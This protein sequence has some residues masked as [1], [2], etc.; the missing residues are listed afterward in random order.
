M[1]S[2]PAS[3]GHHDHGV[4][5]AF[6]PLLQ[7][8][9]ESLEAERDLG[10][11][12]EVHLAVDQDGKGR[13]EPR[14]AAHELHQSDPVA[15]GFRFRVGRASRSPRLGDGGLESKGLLHERD[16][17]VDGLGN[18][19]HADLE[20]P[21]PRLVADRLRTAQRP[22]AADDEQ[23]ADLQVFQRLHHLRRVLWP[24]G[25]PQDRSA[26]LVDPHDRLR[27]QLERRVPVPADETFVAEAE[28]VDRPDAIVVMQAEHDRAYD[29]VQ[30]R[31]DPAAGHDPARKPRR[32]EEQHFPRARRLHRGRIFPPVVPGLQVLEARVIEDALA[33]AREANIRH[34][35]ANQALTESRYREVELAV[36]HVRLLT[37]RSGHAERS[38]R[39]GH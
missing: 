23:D 9:Q 37:I 34:R 33:V 26:D 36:T 4:A 18:A 17:V 6:D 5:P 2:W 30:P 1:R 22:V 8:R 31:A 21:P 15:R 27:R 32:V 35:R 13:D 7:Q 3:F 28:P 10:N 19:D 14:V 39:R 24:A 20:A 16:V 25:G 11:Q 12:T 29:V 38:R